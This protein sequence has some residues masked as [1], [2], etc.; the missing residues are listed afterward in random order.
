M[1]REVPVSR[2]ELFAMSMPSAMPELKVSERYLRKSAAPTTQPLPMKQII[3]AFYRPGAED[4]SWV[5][6]LVVLCSK[7][8]YSHCELV[9]NDGLATSIMAGGTVFCKLRSFN[10]PN[11]ILRGFNVTAHQ[12]D[13]MY[14]YAL[15]QSRKEIPFSNRLMLAPMLGSLVAPK[16][17]VCGT[18]CS[19][20]IV[21]V[22]QHGQVKWSECIDADM[23][24]PSMLF[25]VT[26]N[27][28][29]VCFNTIRSKL[30]NMQVQ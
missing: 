8:P 21:K 10:N 23:C 22:L 14:Q 30:S 4:P 24:S 6:K 13:V 18:F 3:L 7:H 19:Q 5:N 16:Y 12:H 1:R 9:F 2:G 25:D 20:H 28:T 11:Y 26:Q 15:E 27:V 29:S 17:N